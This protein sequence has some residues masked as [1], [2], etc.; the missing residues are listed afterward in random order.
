MKA[1]S[2]NK[3][4]SIDGAG[5]YILEQGDN[6]IKITV[7]LHSGNATGTAWGCDLSYDYVKINALYRT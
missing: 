4:A 1:N 6:E 2:K 5:S 3:Q 7:N